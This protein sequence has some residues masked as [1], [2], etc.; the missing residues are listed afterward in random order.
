MAENIEVQNPGLQNAEELGIANNLSIAYDQSTGLLG[1]G[2]GLWGAGR[3][4]YHGAKKGGDWR[5]YVGA[6]AG[7]LGALASGLGTASSLVDDP[8]KKGVLGLLGSGAGTLAGGTSMLKGILDITN[9]NTPKKL[10]KAEQAEQVAYQ[11]AATGNSLL[12]ALKHG[13]NMLTSKNAKGEKKET[14][15]RVGSGFSLVG[16]LLGAL[17]SGSGLSVNFIKND[18]AKGIMKLVGAGAGIASGAMNMLASGLGMFGTIRKMWKARKQN[19][20]AAEPEQPVVEGGAE[21]GQP[22]VV[23]GGAEP[24]QQAPG[25][26]NEEEQ[27]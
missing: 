2:M 19:Q 11:T 26:V 3:S 25:N 7:G 1:T 14:M 17:A 4:L 16:S 13:K 9:K 5:N 23:E 12:Q 27:Q 20:Q 18:K 24:E 8:K 22:P 15:E 6:A 10:T 21:P